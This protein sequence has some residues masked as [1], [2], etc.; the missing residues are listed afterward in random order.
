[1][2]LI[3]NNKV[4][5]LIPL[6]KSS[7]KGKIIKIIKNQ[8]KR[9][10]IIL[11]LTASFYIANAQSIS[12][13]VIASTG[14]NITSNNGSLS[15]TMGEM[16]TSTLISNDWIL[17]QGFHQSNLSISSGIKSGLSDHKLSLYPNP[18]KDYIN[19][20]VNSR[21]NSKYKY[22]LIDVS[23]RILLN[24]EE[25][26]NLFKISL[27]GFSPSLYYLRFLDEKGKFLGSYKIV[28]HGF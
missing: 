25:Y 14:G 23:G 27:Q 24:K 19:V 3:N 18:A 7:Y 11:F 22:E 9:L 10:L 16:L 6:L 21:K 20:S 15:W 26:S 13:S 12:Q 8:M 5:I 17:T 1:M 4:L 28:K 2:R